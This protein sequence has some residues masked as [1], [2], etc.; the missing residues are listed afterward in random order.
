MQ[1]A[2]ATDM[3][4][5]LKNL[6]RHAAAPPPGTVTRDIRGDGWHVRLDL[7]R[8]RLSLEKGSERSGRDRARSRAPLALRASRDRLRVRASRARDDRAAVVAET[9]VSR[10]LDRDEFRAHCDRYKTAARILENL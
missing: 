9:Y 6:G 8:R 4:D 3:F 10:L 5:W 7:A 1:R 2:A